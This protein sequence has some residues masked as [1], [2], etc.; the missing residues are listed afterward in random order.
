[1]WFHR[2]P[3]LPPVLNRQPLVFCCLLFAPFC[4]LFCVVFVLPCFVCLVLLF[5]FVCCCVIRYLVY[6]LTVLYFSF[7]LFI[8]LFIYLFLLGSRDAYILGAVVL[9]LWSIQSLFS[10]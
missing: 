5:G 1:M 8:Y 2:Q 7:Y 4:S 10:L 9:I 6:K 3:T